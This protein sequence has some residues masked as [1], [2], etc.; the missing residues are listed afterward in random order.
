MAKCLALKPLW[1]HQNWNLAP[2]PHLSSP[3]QIHRHLVDL[4]GDLAKLLENLLENLGS[5]HDR[6]KTLRASG[7]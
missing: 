5:V 4:K 1:S 6:I 7:K 3:P 2:R